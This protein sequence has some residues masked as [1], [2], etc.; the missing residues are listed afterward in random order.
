MH[1]L[2][3]LAPGSRSAEFGRNFFC[4]SVQD[5]ILHILLQSMWPLCR[6]ANRNETTS[7]DKR[8]PYNVDHALIKQ[9]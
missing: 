5:F 7:L 6:P 2:R 1:F 3:D 8:T 4:S 9:A